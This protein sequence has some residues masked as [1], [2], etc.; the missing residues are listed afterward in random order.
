MKNTKVIFMGTPDFSVPVFKMLIEETDVVLVVTQPDKPVGRHHELKPTPIKEVA[1]ENNIPVFQPKK[2]KEE[3]EK[4]LN[5]PCDII[6]TCA[7]G[8]IIRLRQCP[9]FTITKISWWRSNSL[10]PFKR[11]R[12]NR[13]DHYVYG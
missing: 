13:S 4:I 2:I 1:L 10:V 11:R 8:Q 5:T 7:Y 6:I 9:C 12:K 3:Y